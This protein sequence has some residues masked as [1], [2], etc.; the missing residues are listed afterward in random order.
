LNDSHCLPVASHKHRLAGVNVLAHLA[1]DHAHDP[2][3][4]RPQ[5]GL[6]ELPLEHRKRGCR[7][8]DLRVRDGPL[9]LGWPGDRGDMVGLRL[10]DVGVRRCSVVR[11]LVERLLCGGIATRQVGGAGELL[12]RIF[13]PRFC[14]GDLG[15][16]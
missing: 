13:Q 12:L 7:R 9:L 6:V 5:D 15:R 1:D 10:R 2:V 4:R 11:R 14:L 16:E 8:L 3:G